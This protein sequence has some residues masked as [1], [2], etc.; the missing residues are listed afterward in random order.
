MTSSKSCLL[1]S[2]E[3]G[4]FMVAFY[5][6]VSTVPAVAS[7]HFMTNRPLLP[8]MVG[9]LLFFN[10]HD[11]ILAS[12]YIWTHIVSFVVAF[13]LIFAAFM[14]L[15]GLFRVWALVTVHRYRAHLGGRGLQPV[16]VKNI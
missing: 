16:P 10:I 4:C 13:L 1:C 14:L 11:L 9:L 8:V 12:D 5:T 2:L 3:T 6:L 7:G 15:C